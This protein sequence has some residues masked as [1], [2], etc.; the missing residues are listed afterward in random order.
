MMVAPRWRGI[1][2]SRFGDCHAAW[3]EESPLSNEAIESFTEERIMRVAFTF[4]SLFSRAGPVRPKL[5]P[6]DGEIAEETSRRP[7]CCIPCRRPGRRGN[8]NLHHSS[9]AGRQCAVWWN[10]PSRENA[11]FGNSERNMTKGKVD[12]WINI[13]WATKEK[14]YREKE[15]AKVIYL[16]KPD[17]SSPTWSVQRG[18]SR[19]TGSFRPRGQSIR[20]TPSRSA[21]FPRVRPF[22]GGEG[23]PGNR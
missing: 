7:I 13:P 10:H 23:A 2:K 15:L 18:S 16:L 8:I 11:F 6:I 21:T 9:N 5:L 1:V 22:A 19:A 4:F 20:D 12:T 3:A 14:E 17:T